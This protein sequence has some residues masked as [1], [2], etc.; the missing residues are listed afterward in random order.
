M[1]SSFFIWTRPS[2]SPNSRS[3]RTCF[4]RPR[5]NTPGLNRLTQREA[6]T[7]HDDNQTGQLGEARYHA[8]PDVSDH[9]RK[10]GYKRWKRRRPSGSEQ[11]HRAGKK[12]DRHDAG[13]QTLSQG[14]EN[15]FGKSQPDN[16]TIPHKNCVEWREDQNRD[17]A[18][19]GNGTDSGH[20]P[21]PQQGAERCPEKTRCCKHQIAADTV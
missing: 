9:E 13:E 14:L 17:C 3:S 7:D 12:I 21:Q 2:T 18:D 6:E 5:E 10:D 4:R 11:R 8:E 1:R 20:A 16:A 19:G 15:V